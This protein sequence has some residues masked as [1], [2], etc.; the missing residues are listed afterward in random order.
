MVPIDDRMVVLMLI[1]IVKYAPEAR[2]AC[3]MCIIWASLNLKLKL[4][5]IIG[6]ADPTWFA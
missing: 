5:H 2:I 6:F 1:I 4:R 3:A